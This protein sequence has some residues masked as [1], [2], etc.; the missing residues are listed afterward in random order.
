MNEDDVR[1]ALKW[2]RRAIMSIGIVV[3]AVMGL[4]AV[5]LIL[6]RASITDARVMI[7]ALTMRVDSIDEHGTRA[8]AEHKLAAHDRAK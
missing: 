7:T 3:F 5:Q 8:L 2:D 4:V 6:I 1:Y